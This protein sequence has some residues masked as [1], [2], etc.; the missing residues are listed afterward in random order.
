VEL[1]AV[2]ERSIVDWPGVG[3]PSAKRFEVRFA[4]M[5]NIG[6]IDRRERNQFDRINL[7]L[8]IADAVAPAGF[9]FWSL[10]EPERHGY[11]TRQD[12]GA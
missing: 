10:P 6:I 7:N 11:V 2:Q 12:L 1:Y 4:S 5:E 8:T 3:S 9:Y